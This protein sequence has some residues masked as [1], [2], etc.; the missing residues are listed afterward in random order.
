[1]RAVLLIVF[2]PCVLA[3]AVA[4]VY[5]MVKPPPETAV[6]VWPL[7]SVAARGLGVLGL[8]ACVAVV[9]LMVIAEEMGAA[10]RSVDRLARMESLLEDLIFVAGDDEKRERIAD[11]GLQRAKARRE[12]HAEAAVSVVVVLIA[13]GLLMAVLMNLNY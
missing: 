2:F 13:L 12:N 4:S 5:L 1:M 6:L 11:R 9:Y 8:L 10:R 3:A 7:V